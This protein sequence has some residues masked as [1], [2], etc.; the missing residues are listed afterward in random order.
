MYILRYTYVEFFFNW[1][2]P[3][4]IRQCARGREAVL[5][6][7]DLGPLKDISFFEARAEEQY[8]AHA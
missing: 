8:G 6:E 3:I 4:L 5:I 7:G 2:I 1:N